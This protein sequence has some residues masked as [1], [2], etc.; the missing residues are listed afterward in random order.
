MDALLQIFP[1]TMSPFKLFFNWRE[2][3]FSE[4]MEI[5]S[6]LKYQQKKLLY[7]IY[8]DQTSS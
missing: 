2:A 4:I 5:G 8:L 1:T 6:S 7:N 3:L